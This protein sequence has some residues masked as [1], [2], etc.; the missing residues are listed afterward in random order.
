MDESRTKPMIDATSSDRIPRGL[1][2]A[3][4]LLLVVTLGGVAAVRMSG[5]E[6][7]EP[8]AEAVMT[9]TLRFEDAPDG[10]VAVI[11]AGTGQVIESIAGE[12]GFLR[13]ALRAMARERRQHGLG[14]E[15][16]FELIGRSDGRL[17]LQDSATGARIDLEA[18]GPTN[19]SVFARLLT[20]QD[21]AARGM[22]PTQGAPYASQSVR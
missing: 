18:F 19:A 13:G 14:A 10:S 20:S 6:L 7:R 17:T 2:L 4:G 11:D 12:Q 5:V 9:R 8:D 21:S 15:Q 3:I 16:P 1:L 22:V